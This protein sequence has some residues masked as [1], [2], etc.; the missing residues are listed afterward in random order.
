[1]LD[2]VDGLDELLRRHLSV[3]G[4]TSPVVLQTRRRAT[5]VGL[6]D[7][8]AAGLG[9]RLLG[10]SNRARQAS[11][12]VVFL[13]V[14][15]TGLNAGAGT[16]IFLIGLAYMVDSHVVVEQFFLHEPA[17]EPF[18]LRKLSDRLRE[19]EVMV[20]FN[21]KS[22]DLPMVVGRFA[23]HRL[24]APLPP[25]HLDLLHPCRRIWGRRLGQTTLGALEARILGVTRDRDVPGAEVPRRYFE[26]L[27]SRDVA[28]M[29]AVLLH[30][31][32]DLLAMIGLAERIEFFL[33]DVRRAEASGSSDLLGLGTLCELRGLIEEAKQCYSTALVG[34][35]S[36]ERA[37]A[38]HRLAALVDQDVDLARV[39]DLLMAVANYPFE[40][41]LPASIQLAKIFEHRTREHV[42]ALA[43]ANRALALTDSSSPQRKAGLTSSL[44]RRIARL[45]RKI[46]RSTV[47]QE[48]RL[49]AGLVTNSV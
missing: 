12:R 46:D 1:M 29:T 10:E 31:Q 20:T 6:S 41:A 3:A 9:S 40:R 37:E 2:D 19:F 43:Y 24:A 13:D 45:E 49:V 39:V 42:R 5:S 34:A 8:R 7:E 17:A 15:T 4:F 27:R 32:A 36:M 38:L 25:M 18:L 48:A 21:G 16:L 30:N 22:F 28:P 26:F 23:L 35:T 11:D 14:E 47:D 44:G 33:A